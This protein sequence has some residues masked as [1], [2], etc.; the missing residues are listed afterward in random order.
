MRWLRWCLEKDEIELKNQT[1]ALILKNQIKLYAFPLLKL[2]GA[3]GSSKLHW[4]VENLVIMATSIP[5]SFIKDEE[6]L[7]FKKKKNKTE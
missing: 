3:S 1:K 2:Y 4:T 5:S 7:Y 6:T